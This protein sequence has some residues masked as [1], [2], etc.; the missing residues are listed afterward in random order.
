M[1]L[2]EKARRSRSS[3]NAMLR[4]TAANRAEL[5]L[6]NGVVLTFRP[7]TPS[8]IGAV[9]DG[10]R[11]A[12]SEPAPVTYLEAKGR[13]EPNP[14]DP[15]YQETLR[16]AHGAAR[17]ACSTTWWSPPACH[18]DSVPAGFFPSRTKAGCRTRASWSRP[19]A[20]PTS[21]TKTTPSSARC[22]WLQLLRRRDLARR[23]HVQQSIP[24]ELA[25]ISETE[26]QA[27][28]GCL[29]GYTRT[30]SRYGQL[31]L[32]QRVTTGIEVIA[33]SSPAS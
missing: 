13:D 21:S 28:L 11:I 31:P 3:A 18:I 10:A 32:R 27:A 23:P 30:G 24:I 14:N 4:R 2:Q 26:V 29:S 33:P 12:V 8:L 17:S 15:A 5:T 16:R 20:W 9:R 7:V 6:S 19:R 22:T 1:T 25:G